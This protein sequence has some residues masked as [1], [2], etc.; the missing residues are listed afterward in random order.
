MAILDQ[1][2]SLIGVA[3]ARISRG[4]YYELKDESIVFHKF[5]FGQRVI[6]KCDIKFW[7]I[8]PEMGVDFVKVELVSGE[9]LLLTDKRNDLIGAL[10]KI[11]L[12]RKV[13]DEFDRLK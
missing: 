11:A 13:G 9:G 5:P 3:F 6:A 12:D 1:I 10:N 4:E 2:V 8:I 7:S